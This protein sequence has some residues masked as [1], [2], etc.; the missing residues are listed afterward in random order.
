MNQLSQKKPNT[1]SSPA[2]PY[3]P[4]LQAVLGS[5]DVQLEEELGRYRRQRGTKKVASHSTGRPQGQKTLDLISVRATGGRTQPQATAAIAPESLPAPIVN[6]NSIGETEAR[7]PELDTPDR[8]IAPHQTFHAEHS[9]S[10]LPAEASMVS[11]VTPTPNAPQEYLE[12]SEALQQSLETPKPSVESERSFT[13]NLFTPLGVGSMLLLL[14]S[15]A[16][17]G[18]VAMNPASLS[19]LPF[20]G[21]FGQ[22]TPTETKTAAIPAGGSVNKTG[23]AGIPNSPNLASQEFVDLNLK[24]LSTIDPKI[25]PLTQP[26]ATPSPQLPVKAPAPLPGAVSGVP[27]DLPSAL[28]PPSIQSGVLPQVNIQQSAAQ[29]APDRSN[30]QGNA[31]GQKPAAS[32]P[33]SATAKSTSAKAPSGE[34]ASASKRTEAVARFAPGKTPTEN[35]AAANKPAPATAKS[36]QPKENKF[37]VVMVYDGDRSLAEAKKVVSDARVRRLRAGEAIQLSAFPSESEAQ[38]K[39][40]TLRKQGIS[41]QVYRL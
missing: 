30:K 22:K 11:S 7:N 40:E 23:E 28:L 17:L 27:L 34:K 13:E 12:S 29:T 39:V 5:L 4:A 38:K 36:T 6:T 37:L 24:S 32:K 18:Y 19:H 31:N 25:S 2:H 14:L 3:S 26:L 20:K 9:P 15:S 21:A 1:T 41:A 10:L 16:T 8:P 35:Q 33:T